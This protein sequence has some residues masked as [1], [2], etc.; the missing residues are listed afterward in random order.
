MKRVQSY[1]SISL[2]KQCPR[3]WEWK[4]VHRQHGPSNQYA[5]RGTELHAELEAFFN[6]GPYPSANKT[7]RPWQR[8]ME[9]LLKYEPIS[10][11]EVAVDKDWNEVPYD[12]PNAMIRGKIDLTYLDEN[13]VR[14]NLDWKSGRIHKSHVEQGKAY[15]AMTSAPNNLFAAHFVYLDLPIQV[16]KSNYSHAMRKV[17]QANIND[18]IAHIE[19]D[20]VYEPTPSVDACRYCELSIKRGGPCTRAQ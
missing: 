16:A 2:Y 14:F 19:V 10:E 4:Y 3:H 7:L 18:I 1:S 12:D 8:Y 15:T 5:D 11:M 6:G 17:F 20:E 9:G 13:N